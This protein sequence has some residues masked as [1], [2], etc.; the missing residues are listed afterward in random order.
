MKIKSVFLLVTFLFLSAKCLYAGELHVLK[1]NDFTAFYDPPLKLAALE[2]AD[3]Y[4]GI[5]ADLEHTFGWELK[6]KPSILLIK[7]RWQFQRMA[8]SPLTVAFAVPGKNLIV[9]DHSRMNMNPFNLGVI[10]KH[11]LCHLL[12]HYHIKGVTLPRWLEEGICQWASDGIGDIV[13]DQKRSLLNKAILK[14]SLIS[15]PSLQRGFPTDKVSLLLAYEESK[16]LVNY[17]I[18]KFGKEGL[19]AV[20][21]YMKQGQNVDSAV[22]TAL[23]I[24]LGELEKKWH[25]SLRKKLTWFT[26]L[27]YHIYEILFALA[28][29]TTI[30]AFIR[31]IMKKRAYMKKEDDRFYS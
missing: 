28:A 18:G 26:Y 24:P 3:L 15:L 8:E 12:L 5:K 10:L 29:L 7:D 6:V 21:T 13:I 27:S 14:G 22:F 19:L 1:K 23:S 17:I 11:E 31:L 2:V 25:R 30:Y 4:T 9:I 20:L 16:S